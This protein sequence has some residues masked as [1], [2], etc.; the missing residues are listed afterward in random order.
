M[1]TQHELA[2]R[3]GAGQLQDTRFM[4]AAEKARVLKQ[5]ETFLKYGCKRE[6]FTKP[7]YNYLIQHCSFIAHYDLNGFYDTYF[8]S[9]DDTRQFLSQFDDRKGIPRSVEYGDT[10]WICGGNDVSQG[11]YDINC[12]MVTIA[13]KYIPGL[14][15][16]GKPESKGRRH[17][18]GQS[19]AGKARG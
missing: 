2:Q 18:S 8:T 4:S 14:L 19:L 1:T 9:G 11:Y 6:H 17:R 10:Y 3:R 7:L 16:K 5:W 13:G 15:K 12:E